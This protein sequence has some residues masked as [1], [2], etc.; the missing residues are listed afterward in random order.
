MVTSTSTS[1]IL[2]NVSIKYGKVGAVNDLTLEIKQKEL[3]VLLGPSGCGKT[4]TLM[5]IAGLVRPVEGEVWLGDELVT[6]PEQGIFVRPQDRN[7]AM[8][9]QD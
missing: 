1:V 8:V 5:S 7:I 9:F 3:F 4:T 6:S 2:R